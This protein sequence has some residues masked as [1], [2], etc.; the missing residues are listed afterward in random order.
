[1]NRLGFKGAAFGA[2]HA[3][4]SALESVRSPVNLFTHLASADLPE[5]SSTS[6]QLALFAARDGIP[7]RLN[8]AWRIPPP[9]CSFPEHQADLGAAGPPALRRLAVHRL[10]RRRLC[11]RPAMTLHSHVIAVKDL[12]PGSGWVTAA[13]GP[14]SVPR[15]WRWRPWDTATDIRGACHRVRRRWS[16]ANARV[17]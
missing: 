7:A 12:S 15:A 6:E 8:A 10:H 5:L 11:L 9:C 1:M 4:L 3:A 17:W 13:T 16:T 14:P 2:A